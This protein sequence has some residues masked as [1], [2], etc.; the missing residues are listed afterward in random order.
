MPFYI[1][2]EVNEKTP[3]KPR[4]Y[5]CP[6]CPKAFV[7]LEHRTR[8]IRTHTGEKPHTCSFL[9]C[10]KR[11][12]RSDELT[13]HTRI[14]ITPSKRNTERRSTSTLLPPPK[15]NYRSKTANHKVAFTRS[16]DTE[17]KSLTDNNHHHY[18][19]SDSDSDHMFTPESSPKLGPFQPHHS[20][21]NLTL[22]P[23]LIGM[24]KPHFVD[25]PALESHYSASNHNTDSSDAPHLPSI[26]FLLG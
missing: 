11:F 23:L 15:S 24:R 1:K 21:S 26:K 25:C 10:D 16:T 19:S 22:P 20:K 3:E 5:Q 7:R 12:S 14:H 9:N 4:P 18:Y 13:R 17:L 6:V 2:Q 8:H